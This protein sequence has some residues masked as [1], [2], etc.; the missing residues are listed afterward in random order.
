[1]Y[2]TSLYLAIDSHSR[3]AIQKGTSLCSK[4][5][6]PD[7]RSGEWAHSPSKT[8]CSEHRELPFSAA[9]K[10]QSQMSPNPFK[11]RHSGLNSQPSLYRMSSPEL[12][13]LLMDTLST[14]QLICRQIWNRKYFISTTFLPPNVH[15]MLGGKNG[16]LK[17]LSLVQICIS[18]N[19]LCMTILYRQYEEDMK[20]WLKSCTCLVFFLGAISNTVGL[21]WQ[22]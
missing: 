21:T 6:K 5:N 22:A 18:L 13:A 12:L 11:W 2:P 10:G 20:L 17:C 15:T 4:E 8:N 7:C 16:F 9:A 1:M 3:P 19:T 14:V